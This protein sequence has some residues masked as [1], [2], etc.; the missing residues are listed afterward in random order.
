MIGTSVNDT[1]HAIFAAFTQQWKTTA[2]SIFSLSFIIQ[3]IPVV[4]VLAWI[5]IRS[6]SVFVLTYILVGAPLMAIWN[7]VVFRVGWSLNSELSGR[8]LE[9]AMISRTPMILVM[10]GK[11]LAQLIYGIPTGIIAF[12][13]M[14]L[15][16]REFPAVDNL[17]FLV[18]SLLFVIL[19]ITIVS[20]LF[21][22][23]MVIVGG[24]AGF[25]NSIMPLGVLV[26]GFMFP[27]DQLP[28][29][30]EIMARLL[31]TSWAMYGVWHSITGIESTWSIIGAWAACVLSSAVWL[32]ITY[33]MFK[34]VEK[35][36]R[37]TGI[38]GT[39]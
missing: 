2:T 34:A 1:V 36:I 10:L 18:F 35:R 7:G 14:I 30:L 23:L 12:L 4:A 26:S 17:A 22:P 8:T 13:T 5:A 29:G 19:G 27:I 32:S 24:R 3:S 38:L 28:L 33:L 25:F 9:F 37:I 20:L 11:T 16:T 21:S 39:Y 31:P 6:D 15:I